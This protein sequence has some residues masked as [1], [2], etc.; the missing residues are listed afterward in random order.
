MQSRS[1][2]FRIHAKQVRRKAWWANQKMVNH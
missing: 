2:Q 1:D